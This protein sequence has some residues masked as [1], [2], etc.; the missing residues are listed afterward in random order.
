MIGRWAD[1]KVLIRLDDGR[2]FEAPVPADVSDFDVGDRADLY[3]DRD[4]R[5]TGWY[6]PERQQGVD[7]RGSGGADERPPGDVP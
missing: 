3:F 1:D 2:V 7:L 4:G 6:L 5:V